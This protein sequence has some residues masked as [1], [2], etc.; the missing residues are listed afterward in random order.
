[1][2]LNIASPQTGGQACI[3]VED[4]RKLR[5]FYDKR[6]SQD[7]DG[8]ELGDEFKGYI[9]RITGGNDKQ[10][11]A[12]KQG[13]LINGRTRLLLT[14]GSTLYRQR[15][16][17]E[18]KR[19]SVR[20]SF[21]GPDICV[22]NLLV[23]KKG[24]ADIKGVTDVELPK[25]RGP[26]RA[27]NIRKLYDLEKDDP[28]EPFVVKREIT[29]AKGKKIVKSP[30]IQRQVTPLRLQRKRRI[31]ALKKQAREKSQKEALEYSK[32]LQQ[33]LNEAKER[34]R[35]KNSSRRSKRKSATKKN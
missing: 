35:S 14:K 21:V 27:T 3:E 31:Q 5:V 15:R 24:D 20:G 23:I 13:V 6:M 22:L 8:D 25:R 9:F 32:L 10:G 4:E 29:N 26:K 17:G 33:R 7:V 28:L 2:K 18:K 19:K 12:M 11:F 16:A 1:M 34:R 30:K